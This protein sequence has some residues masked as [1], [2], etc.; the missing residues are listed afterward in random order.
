MD[1]RTFDLSRFF[2]P[3][4]ILLSNLV[5]PQGDRWHHILT[6]EGMYNNTITAQGAVCDRPLHITPWCRWHFQ[7]IS[8]D[9]KNNAQKCVPNWRYVSAL[10]SHS[11]APSGNIHRTSI[12]KH[13]WHRI[14]SLYRNRLWFIL[15]V[16]GPIH[17]LT[18][19][20]WLPVCCEASQ[21]WNIRFCCYLAVFTQGTDSVMLCKYHDVTLASVIQI[22]L[23]YSPFSWYRVVLAHTELCLRDS[24]QRRKEQ[25]R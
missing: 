11:L 5:F 16:F 7:S 10:S 2:R 12:F 14:A 17:A 23:R 21:Y 9:F 15:F 4:L 20:D 19:S 3:I 6:D 22:S 18:I 8:F 1:V 13:I 24:S 25:E